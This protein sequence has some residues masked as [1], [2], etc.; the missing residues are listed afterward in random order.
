M[1]IAVL[2]HAD[3]A[4][5]PGFPNLSSS[6]ANADLFAER[7]GAPDTAFEVL[8]LAPDEDFVKNLKRVAKL[9]GKHWNSLL[10][11][12]FGYVALTQDGEPALL[13][14]TPSVAC[15][16]L[17]RLK[18]FLG[19]FG[20][21]Q[22]ILD[23]V[24][25]T[26]V[27]GVDPGAAPRRLSNDLLAGFAA[28]NVATLLGVR[29]WGALE[30]GVP[31]PFTS[32]FMSALESAAESADGTHTT[33]DQYAAMCSHAAAAAQVSGIGCA[34][35]Q[36][37]FALRAG[38]PVSVVPTLTSTHDYA[39]S[40]KMSILPPAPPPQFQSVPAL[41]PLS[42]V[43]ASVI[44]KTKPGVAPDPNQQPRAPVML[45]GLA[46]V[47]VFSGGATHPAPRIRLDTLMEP[48]PVPTEAVVSAPVEI[49]EFDDAEHLL[50]LG[51]EHAA[52]GDYFA[53]QHEF[54][55]ALELLEGETERAGVLRRLALVQ[56]AL[57]NDEQALV[58][59][60]DAVQSAPRVEGL[61]ET[62]YDLVA[63]RSVP[64]AETFFRTLRGL[65]PQD[66][67]QIELG[68]WKDWLPEPTRALAVAEKLLALDPT[69]DAALME[70]ADLTA[71]PALPQRVAVLER[72]S[73]G[74]YEPAVRAALLV[75]AA[76]LVREELGQDARAAELA[77]RALDLEPTHLA[78][79]E[80]V[81]AFLSRA[82]QWEKLA[83][84]YQSFL[85]Q[86][87]TPDVATKACTAFAKV[88]LGK[89]E[90]EERAIA[91][92][93]AGIVHSPDDIH[94]RH[95]AA[96]LCDSIDLK[97]RAG[98]HY[99]AAVQAEPFNVDAL[100][101]AYQ[102][103]TDVK[104]A[105]SAW[106]AAVA[107]EHLGQATNGQR[108]LAQTHSHRGPVQVR[109]RVTA[110]QWMRALP[111]KEDA[112]LDAM[113]RSLSASAQ[114]LH[115]ANGRTERQVLE[116]ST[117]VAPELDSSHL[118]ATLVSAAE[119][120]D[121]TAPRLLLTET[122]PSGIAPAQVGFF[123]VEAERSLGTVQ[124][125]AQLA[126]LSGRALAMFR[127]ENYLFAF[128]AGSA[129]TTLV[130]AALLIAEIP[131]ARNLDAEVQELAASFRSNLTP[132]ALKSVKQHS[133]SLQPADLSR[134]VD[135]YVQ[136]IERQCL[137]AGLLAC[138][139]LGVA[140]SVTRAF[141]LVG[142]LTET[143]QRQELIR[144]GVNSAY[145]RLRRELGIAI[146]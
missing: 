101:R 58:Y 123:A 141:P 143:E 76:R 13:L 130:Q 119:F 43:A 116:R 54:Q 94:L 56:R 50:T 102:H 57:G 127:P 140:L 113:F 18:R 46:P 10:F 87:L 61:L 53:A 129:A 1:R 60:A 35:S 11:G 133:A 105:D 49:T 110:E 131:G 83:T 74:Q 64:E 126:F 85:E 38:G 139:N 107:L 23:A 16:P 98:R 92:Y 136:R 15:L 66:A 81:A 118:G 125:T 142:A 90:D 24:V 137:R 121:V 55:R 103:F 33:G 96:A 32:L 41:T 93:E 88:C 145:A 109:E 114:A 124:T 40:L 4:P 91:A 68:F 34:T 27:P 12:F 115:L 3:Y 108:E 84:L 104:D 6:R 144:F 111:D 78:A 63:Q 48:E 7:L 95:R 72:L 73:D 97:E 22:V 112:A 138:G 117:Q 37:D 42:A 70:L 52:R 30:T 25:G 62:T 47:P 51:D 19:C 17:S 28:A 31:T 39:A 2:A 120:F 14:S 36:P 106:Q 79:L 80:L 146:V 86:N 134:R 71:G 100:Q 26:E 135:L 67:L 132:E 29:P 21:S 99:R 82:K 65:P 122:V 128:Y 59:L 8:R 20:A 44:A 75:E 77:R 5:L 69:A 89:L 45:P 9:Y